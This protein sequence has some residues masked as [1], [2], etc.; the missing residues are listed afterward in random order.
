MASGEL[1]ERLLDTHPERS[2][3]STGH[4]DKISTDGFQ[5]AVQLVKLGRMT[6][7]QM[8]T[9]FARDY[10]SQLGE[11]GV[12]LAQQPTSG[13]HAGLLEANDLVTWVN[14]GNATADLQRAALL[15]RVLVM[16]DVHAA[17]FDTPAGIRAALN[18]SFPTPAIPDRAG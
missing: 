2:A 6:L 9:L 7:D 5:A 17:P 14:A 12:P 16:A 3:I 11:P 15:E 10:G 4:R 1:Y 13:A 18:A 8:N